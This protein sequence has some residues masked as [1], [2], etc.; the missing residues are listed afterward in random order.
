MLPLVPWLAA[1]FLLITSI[2]LLLSRDWR[3]SLGLLAGQ[4]FAVFWLILAHWPLTMSAANLVTGWMSA[5]VLGMTQLSIKEDL[6]ADGSW[7]QGRLFRL[8]AAGLVLITIT[9]G[10]QS[11]NTWLPEA[12]Q[13]VIFGALLLIGMG[14]LHLGITVQPFRVVLGLL[15]TLSGFEILYAVIENSIL[16]AGLLSVVTLG[17]SLAG[18]YLLAASALEATE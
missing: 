18:S 13:P 15:T 7:P 5:A 9:P 10:T 4:Y 6:A 16:V 17:L 2:G 12:G 3:W 1:I 8:L 14:L 11:V